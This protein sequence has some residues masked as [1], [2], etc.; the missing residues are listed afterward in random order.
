MSNIF[1]HQSLNVSQAANAA[2]ARDIGSGIAGPSQS[3]PKPAAPTPK[4][5]V[6]PSNPYANYSNA[7][8][9]GFV[10]VEEEHAVAQKA[11]KESEGRIGDWTY[12]PS[13]IPSSTQAK[14]EPEPVLAPVDG[15]QEDRVWRFEG[16]KKRRIAIGMGDLYEPGEIVVLR[17]EGEAVK[18]ESK[19]E[20]KPES[21]EQAVPKLSWKPIA[22]KKAA[23]TVSPPTDTDSNAEGAVKTE[24]IDE[25]IPTV[26]SPPVEPPQS[27]HSEQL[28][29]PNPSPVKEEPKEVPVKEDENKPSSAG[30]F[31]K[32]KAPS[33]T[34]SN[35]SRGTRG[36]T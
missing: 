25:T 30:L 34:A 1:T 20:P 2:Y 23:D 12:I 22:L 31:R 29:P 5:P 11:L 33:T 8:Q 7:A 18:E 9:L 13:P 15:E 36:R 3:S 24:E 32:R 21:L 17:K 10:D 26:P 27:V 6:K 35:P 4:K 16:N 19:E 14:I 28:L